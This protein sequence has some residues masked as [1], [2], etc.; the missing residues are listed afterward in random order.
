LISQPGQS[1]RKDV[2]VPT[3]CVDLLPTLLHLADKPI[4]A[5]CE[6]QVLPGF[7]DSSSASDR[8]IFTLEAKSNP[9]TGPLKTATV[10]MIK[11][12]YKIIHYF[13][14]KRH[15][16][17]DEIYDLANDPAERENRQG[18]DAIPAA[19][20]LKWELAAKLK[21][22]NQE[23]RYIPPQTVQPRCLPAMARQNG[24][25]ESLVQLSNHL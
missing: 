22:A 20:D 25:W 23:A 7:S 14:Y 3:S 2:G 17:V 9:K 8:S 13:G 6:G 10:M 16:D 19:S 12:R 5:W 21:Q 24:D 11:G 1:R 15:R 4:P 18:Q